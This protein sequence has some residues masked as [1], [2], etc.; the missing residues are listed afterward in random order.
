MINLS[1]EQSIVRVLEGFPGEH[2]PGF[3][4]GRNTHRIEL[5]VDEKPISDEESDYYLLVF[6]LTE[7]DRLITPTLSLEHHNPMGGLE[8]QWT[9][10]IKDLMNLSDEMVRAIENMDLDAAAIEMAAPMLQKIKQL[11]ELTI[12]NGG[13]DWPAKNETVAYFDRLQALDSDRV[14]RQVKAKGQLIHSY[15]GQGGC[16]LDAEAVIKAVDRYGARAADL[17]N[18]FMVMGVRQ[19]HEVAIIDRFGSIVL[20]ALRLDEVNSQ[21][22]TAP[23][24]NPDPV[25]GSASTA[26][27]ITDQYD[28]TNSGR[29][30]AYGVTPATF[31]RI[32]TEFDAFTRGDVRDELILDINGWDE[33]QLEPLW[34]VLAKTLND[35]PPYFLFYI[36]R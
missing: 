9:F 10:D 23:Y 27:D 29:I 3:G 13:I 22:A 30:E 16:D 4:D 11:H 2:Y 24:S 1:L 21:T 6:V 31:E 14:K 33:K 32:W 28:E 12:L 20:I 19:N 26:E 8:A 15:L 5:G 35:V 36:A 25:E 17:E 7:E 34:D 18:P